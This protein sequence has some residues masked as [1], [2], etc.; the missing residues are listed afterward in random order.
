MIYDTQQS[1]DQ[2]CINTIR[3]LAIDAIQQA[4]SGHPGMPLGAAP[5]AYILWTRFLK[6]NPKNPRWQNRDRFILSGG[7]GSMLLYSLLHLT[8]YDL[9]LDEIKKFRQLR[10]KTPGHPEYNL[11][12]GVETTTGPLGQGFA[13][14]VGLAI[15]QKYLAARY[16]R[17]GFEIVDYYIY[18]IVTDGDLM[19]GISSEAGSLAGHLK[20]GNLIYL[21]DDNHISIEGKTEI[22]FTEDTVNRF[23]SFGWHVQVLPDGNDIEAIATAIRTA[24]SVKD[25][26]S[27]IKI[28]THIG[29]GS[30]NKQDTPEAH[31]APLGVEEVKLTKRQ[32]GW[33]PEKQFYIPEEVKTFMQRAVVYG[34]QA[35]AKW[36]NLFAEYQKQYPELAEEYLRLQ[37]GTL[38]ENWER[39]I[40]IFNPA[41]GLIATRQASGK[42]L[43][44]IAPQLPTLLGGS[45]DLA[46]ST[47]TILT[48][49][50]DFE[51]ENYSGRNVHFGVREHGMGGILNG[52]ALTDGIIPY[53]ATFLVFSDYMRPPIRLAALMKIKPIYV[54]THDSI[55]L[56]EDGPTHQ[57]IEQL[58]ALRAIPNLLVIR[59]A[60]AT[61]TAVAWKIAIEHRGGP[62][63]LVLTRQKLPII[64]RKKYAA[65]ENLVKGAYVISESEKNPPEIILIATGSEVHLALA[66]QEVLKQENITGVR[67][68][69]MPSW[70]LFERQSIEYQDSVLPKTV[71]KRIAIE[72]GSPLGW[73]KYVGDSGQI[74]GINTFGASAPAEVL[75]KEYGFTV[76]NIVGSVKAI[77]YGK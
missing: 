50:G 5:M 36:K 61:E 65:A 55:A 14:G 37:N 46:P 64:D 29:Y 18:A 12:Y 70:E 77:L 13:N 74:I 56:G 17:P 33:D 57:P 54:F 53:G 43:N 68:V 44:A 15:G 4:N 39:N 26:P 28:R 73:Y 59:P 8:G 31:G 58:M 27:L 3:C 24:Q 1:L 38:P 20:L 48:G 2:L 6:H 67:V 16:N 60:D 10:S 66:A 30:P 69:S 71:K 7:H 25:K 62:V 76:E 21:Y 11:N 40:P 47:E 9:S 34:E 22:T 42:V 45:A 41:L 72:A 63:A 32:L 49:F 51:P 52:L 23:E 19:E 75:L 35:E